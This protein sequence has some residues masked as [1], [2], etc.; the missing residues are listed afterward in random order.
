MTIDIGTYGVWRGAWQTDAAFAAEVERLGYGAL[1]LG[2][3]P[4]GGLAIVDEVLAATTGLKVATG[5]VNVWKDAADVVAASYAR[6]DAAFPDRFLLG[7]GIGHPEATKEYASPYATLVAYVDRLRELGVPGDRIVLAALGDKVLRLSAGA[8]GAHPYLVPPEHTAHARSVLGDGVL[9]APEH[10][11]VVTDEPGPSAESRAIARP[12]VQR[13]YLSLVNYRSNLLRLGWSE[14]DLDDGG[15]DALID[16][17]VAQGDPEYVAAALA[18]HVAAGASHVA[19]QA[20]GDNALGQL[21]A[22]APA[23]GL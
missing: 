13:P 19:I 11:V 7:V 15:S 21:T 3:S 12:P 20:L 10:K 4:D 1:W 2:G 16:A 14:A 18:A 17:L 6:I 9:L 23:L 8:G 22:L 5:I